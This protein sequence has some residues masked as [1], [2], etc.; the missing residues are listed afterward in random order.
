VAELQALAEQQG[1]VGAERA[2]P[3]VDV[4]AAPGDP[5]GAFVQVVVDADIQIVLLVWL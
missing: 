4:N 1:H 5:G 3:I 2:V